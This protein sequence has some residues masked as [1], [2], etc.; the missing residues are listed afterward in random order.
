MPTYQYECSHCGHAF[1]AWQGILDEPLKRCPE[2]RK[3]KLA[4]VLG[5]PEVILRAGCGGFYACDY[6]KGGAGE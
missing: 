1:D 4:R 6:P 5:T 2:C 3:H